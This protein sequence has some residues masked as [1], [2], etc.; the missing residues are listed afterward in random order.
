MSLKHTG[1]TTP[2]FS[3]TADPPIIFV[4]IPTQQRSRRRGWPVGKLLLLLLITAVLGSGAALGVYGYQ[5]DWIVPGVQTL[6]IPLGA[7]S[8]T[9]AANKLQT[10]WQ[11]QVIVLT[12]ADAIEHTSPQALGVTLDVAATVQR[13]YEQGRYFDSILAVVQGKP[14]AVSPVWQMDMAM[15]EAHLHQI[16]PQFET[17]PMAAS[18]QIVNGQAQALAPK[19]GHKVNVPETLA[20]LGQHGAEIVRDGR[21]PLAMERLEPAILD[22]SSA[23]EQANRLLATSLHLHA[24][25]PVLDEAIDWT[26]PP[27]QWGEWVVVSPLSPGQIE[28]FNWTL[29][30]ERVAADLAAMVSLTDGRFLD[31]DEAI[32][33][34]TRA[35]LSGNS[36]VP[37]RIFHPEQHHIVQAG[38]TLSSI[39]YHY[40]IPYPWL[41]QA[42]P[43]LGDSLSVGQSL[44][45]PSPDKLLPLPIV[46]NKRIVISLPEQKVWVYED[47]GLKWEWVTS[48]GIASSPTAPGIFQIQS[49]EENA[50]AG[51]WDLWMPSFMGIYQPVPTS[52]FMNGFHG[53]PTRNGHDLLWTGDLGHE[54]TYGCILLS[55]ENAQTLFNWAEEGVV[56]EIQG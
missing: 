16:A 43:G 55:N 19:V 8:R 41:Q 11:E 23:V 34:M 10:E 33:A 31:V 29:A 6:G 26:I 32:T 15:A 53:F 42:N 35:I 14:T 5:A 54:V 13:A 22:A 56:V 20:R 50:Y 21:L 46:E 45:I 1:F 2:S 38:E 49:H 36:A 18:V 52:S 25:D 7:Q 28:H 44:L 12:G 30:K 40:G 17:V 51:N 39:G 9:Q 37:V 48:T 47:S 24:Y 4:P 3:Q 27:H